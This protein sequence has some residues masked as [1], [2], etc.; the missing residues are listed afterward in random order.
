RGFD[1]RLRAADVVGSASRL[2]LTRRSPDGE[3]GYPGNVDVEV[4]YTLTDANELSIDSVATTD[5]PTPINLTHHGYFNLNGAGAGTILDHV[6]TIHADAYTPVLESLI[7]TGEIAPVAGTPFD[8]RR[9][10]AIGSR[11]QARDEQLRRAGGYDH[12]FVVRGR[13]GTLRAAAEV[14]APATGHTLAVATTEPGLQL[15]SGNF[16]DGT[17]AGK[18]GRLY[19][20]RSAFCLEPQHFPDSPNQPAFPTT[21]LE[22]GQ[23][24]RSRT[25]FT[26]GVRD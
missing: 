15:Y 13:D 8:F 9:A 12:N 3:E 6:L 24:Y 7:P 16:L 18:G 23:V 2:R 25:V 17:L 1:K 22:P 11:I 19:A 10:A 26:F 14:W 4:T 20:H 5:A 21:I